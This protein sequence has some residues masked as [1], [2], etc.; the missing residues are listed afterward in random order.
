[1]ST[2]N[3]FLFSQSIPLCEIGIFGIIFL[4]VIQTVYTVFKK[5][6]EMTNIPD[7]YPR[8]FSPHKS[9]IVRKR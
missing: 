5:V 2:T 1:M 6:R 3:N 7:I 9:E 8:D 4:S